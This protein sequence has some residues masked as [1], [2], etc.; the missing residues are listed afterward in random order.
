MI[1]TMASFYISHGATP[2]PN[3]VLASTQSPAATAPPAPSTLVPRSPSH[4]SPEACPFVPSGRSKAQRWEDSSPS[5]A[6]A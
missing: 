6:S 1:T 3:P 2:T 5:V 4:P